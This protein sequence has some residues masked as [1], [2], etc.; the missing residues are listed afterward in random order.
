[1][2]LT[3]EQK[4]AIKTRRANRREIDAYYGLAAALSCLFD[5]AGDREDNDPGALAERAKLVP[6]G[7]RDLRC[8]TAMLKGLL[9]CMLLTF[10]PEKRRSIGKQ[11]QHLRIKTVF[12]PEAHKDPEMFMIPI[13]DLGLLVQAAAESCKVRMCAPGE[14]AQCDLGKVIDRASFVSRGDRAWWEVFEQAQRWD[15][16]EE[17]P[18]RQEDKG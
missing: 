1:M 16:G 6:G 13:S 9:P 2:K 18:G 12:G 17:T 8:A 4:K 5:A 14:C 11:M 7:L 10:E 3:D 15:I